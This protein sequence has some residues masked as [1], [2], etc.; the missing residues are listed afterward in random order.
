MGCFGIKI[1]NTLSGY[2]EGFSFRNNIILYVKS[3]SS[4]YSYTSDGKKFMKIML[5]KV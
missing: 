3:T 1:D 4:S 2:A 5:E